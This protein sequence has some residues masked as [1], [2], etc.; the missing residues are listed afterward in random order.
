VKQTSKKPELFNFKSPRISSSELRP[1]ILKS[2]NS[3]FLLSLGF[4]LSL[5]FLFL[6]YGFSED[7]DDHSAIILATVRTNFVIDSFSFTIWTDGN[8]LSDKG[9]M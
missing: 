6:L 9:M 8:T 3:G 7:I 4:R 2:N 1:D 5:E